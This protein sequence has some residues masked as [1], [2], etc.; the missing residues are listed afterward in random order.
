M[1]TLVIKHKPLLSVI[2]AVYNGEEFIYDFFNCLLKQELSSW[3]LIIV[4][5][6]SID[7]S[8]DIIKKWKDRFQFVTILDQD[9]QGVSVARNNGL[10]LAKGEYV[11]FP[12]IDDEMHPEMYNHLLKIAIKDNLDV[13]TC[14]GNYIYEDKRKSKPIFPM[15]KLWS[16]TVISGPEWLERALNSRKFLH[17]T[18][19]NIYRREFLVQRDHKF[20]PGLHH[21]DI[22]WTT[23]VLLTAKRVR[24]INKQY[25]NYFIH[26][27]SVSHTPQD[28]YIRIRTINNYIK[29]L[30]MLDF[31]NKRYITITKDIPAC[32]WQ[33]SKEGLGILHTINDIES[34]I[35]RD[36]MINIL[37]ERGVW[38]LIWKNAER[39]HL[40][41]RLGKRYIKLKL[42]HRRILKSNQK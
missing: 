7:N 15:K 2:V 26:S 39:F 11:A 40:R 32:R 1:Q 28:D 38:S 42:I 19:L 13:A 29:I 41:W 24:Y 30:E 20:E 9:N 34:Q 21:Q 35:T 8:L 17:V 16:T 27:K 14:N 3:E 33:I 31:I 12:D 10:S 6:G 22:P 4:N 5:D 18:W 23:A 25:Y 36:K 37:F